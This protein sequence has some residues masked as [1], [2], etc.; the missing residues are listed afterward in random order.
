MVTTTTTAS[1]TFIDLATFDEIEAFM[2][3][4]SNAVS[5]FV[6][7]VQ[8]CNWASFIPI[9]LRLLGT[10]DF[11]EN[12]ATASVNRSGDYLLQVWFRAR[13]PIVSM[14]TVNSA[15]LT[16]FSNARVGWCH[17]LMHNIFSDITLKTGG[18]KEKRTITIVDESCLTI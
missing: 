5:L 2:Y 1:T 15:G 16:I 4:G 10:H 3:G 13:I 17:R 14:K 18:N 8:K 6:R 7:A 11:G 9:S 12:K